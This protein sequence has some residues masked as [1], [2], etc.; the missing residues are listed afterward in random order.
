[1]SYENICHAL[2]VL[3]SKQVF[4]ISKVTSILTWLISYQPNILTTNVVSMFLVCVLF[5]VQ[6]QEKMKTR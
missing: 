3:I 6:D 4:E 5:Q 2:A 1:M